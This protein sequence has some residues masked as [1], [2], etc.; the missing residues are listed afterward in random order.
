MKL[1]LL[2]NFAFNCKL[3]HYNQGGQHVPSLQS[4]DEVRVERDWSGIYIEFE[5][6]ARH[7]TL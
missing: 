6:G 5:A 1:K 4:H 3:R 2:S 7:I